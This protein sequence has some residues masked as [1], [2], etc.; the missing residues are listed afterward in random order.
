MNYE[1]WREKFRN[2]KAN[3][4]RR[5]VGFKMSYEE[6][7]GIWVESG[8]MHQRGIHSGQYVMARHGDKGPYEVGNVKIIPHIENIKERVFSEDA[9]ARIAASRIG[10]PHLGPKK[11]SE[12][13]KQRMAE[14]RRAFW[15]RKRAA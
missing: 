12:Q 9:K 4:V 2:A 15:A 3:A 11:H 7:L 5:G 8:H 14:S 1:G 13:T 6:W 10:K